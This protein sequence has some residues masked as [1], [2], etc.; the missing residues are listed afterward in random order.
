MVW[1]LQGKGWSA[2]GGMVWEEEAPLSTEK[3]GG[4]AKTGGYGKTLTCFRD[5]KVPNCCTLQ[6]GAVLT[7]DPDMWS[8]MELEPPTYTMGRRRGCICTPTPPLNLFL[9]VL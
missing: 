9:L 3:N 6:H 2:E 8:C 7:G 4:D 1:G 5:L